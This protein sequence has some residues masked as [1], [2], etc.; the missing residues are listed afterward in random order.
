MRQTLFYIP[1][2]IFGARLFG[3]NGILFWAILVA[4]I[5][6]VV[7]AIFERKE[8]KD[9]LFLVCSTALGL[10]LVGK[11]GPSI[12]EAGGFPIRGYGVFLTL[13]I[14]LSAALVIWRGKKRW[15]YPQDAIL[16]II[17]VA[18]LF[19]IL[20]ARLFYVA[21]YWSDIRCGSL[22]D[23]IISAIDIT[24]GGLVVYGSVFGGIVGV[25]GY[26]L[27][28][29]LPVL[30][31]LDLFA[32]S[33]ALGIAIGRL[34]C[35]MNGCCFGGVCDVP[36]GIV[37]PPDS[38]AYAQQ[39]D[40]G[41]ISLYGI[42]LAPPKAAENAPT[43]RELLPIKGKRSSLATETFAPA[44]VAS[45][46]PN[47]E[48]EKAGVRP[49]ARICELGVVPQGTFEEGEKIPANLG[50]K[51]IRRFRVD[52]NAQVFYFF[53][54]IWN[55]DS[56]ADV[57]LTLIDPAESDSE[58]TE[59]PSPRIV[60]FHPAPAKAKPVHPTQ[61][62]SSIDALIICALLLLV[63]RFVKRD[64]ATTAGFLIL[65]PIHR[66][67]V[68]LLRNDEESFLGTG[69]TVSQCAS[70]ALLAIGILLLLRAFSRPPKRALEGFFPADSEEVSK[71]KEKNI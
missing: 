52:N 23:T 46:D 17:F 69:L 59:S 36:W 27:A 57:A 60:V 67:C 11:V 47:S 30:A 28:K 40:S 68:E 50:G 4:A 66:F 1:I 53:Q 43:K 38:P 70:V 31:T 61:I 15:N 63:A 65:Y 26:L 39:L 51:K 42:T 58:K 49:G 12:A 41:D 71:E 20:G 34:G 56:S 14:A 10:L 29:K 8:I 6:A 16:G 7:R 21:Q 25:V 48:A 32:P 22:R 18:V 3:F 62:Y 54:N 33:L 5:I 2:E 45:V 64:G 19:G 9:V 37:F 13:A 44:I 55:P 24:K 35:L